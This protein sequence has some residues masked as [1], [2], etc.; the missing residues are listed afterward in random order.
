VLFLNCYPDPSTLAVE[1]DYKD[2]LTA[3]TT[4]TEKCI[5]KQFK[6]AAETLSIVLGSA[7]AVD[8]KSKVEISIRSDLES[9]SVLYSIL[10]KQHWHEK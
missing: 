6:S 9:P 3:L 5:E 7:Q 4:I 10:R 8:P 1:S 2:T